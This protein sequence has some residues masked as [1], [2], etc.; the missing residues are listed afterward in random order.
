MY[1][2]KNLLNN[3]CKT[4]EK[5]RKILGTIDCEFYNYL[6]EINNLF[7]KN[8]YASIIGSKSCPDSVNQTLIYFNLINKTEIFTIQIHNKYAIRITIPLKNSNH[9]YSTTF[10]DIIESYNF[11]KIH[12]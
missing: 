7:K 11:L 8:K 6:Y 3:C 5:E 10:F 4:K 12:I 9:L 2:N 1:K